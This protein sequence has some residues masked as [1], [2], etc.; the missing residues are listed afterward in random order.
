MK[1]TATMMFRPY[2]WTMTKAEALA[3]QAEQIAGYSAACPG[4]AD[5]VAAITTADQLADGEHDVVVINRHIPRGYMIEQFLPHVREKA[6]RVAA[7]DFCITGS[8]GKKTIIT[9]RDGVWEAVTDRR[10]D[11]LKAAHVWEWNT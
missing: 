7:A 6:A 5:M 9:W 1:P 2:R 4:L 10:L 3:I 11:E 8:M